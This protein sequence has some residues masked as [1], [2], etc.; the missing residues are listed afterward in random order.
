MRK[1]PHPGINGV[2]EVMEPMIKTHP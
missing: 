1:G 2:F